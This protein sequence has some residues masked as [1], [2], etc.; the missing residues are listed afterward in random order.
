[1]SFASATRSSKEGPMRF[2]GQSAIVT[3]AAS[4]IGLAIARRLEGEGARVLP[5]DRNAA[6][7]AV[8]ANSGL[9]LDLT[10]DD[11]PMRVAEEASRRFGTVDILVNNAGGGAL[12]TL[13]D[14]DDAL[15]DAILATNL[16]AV[17]RVTREIIPLLARPGGRIVNIASIF[18]EVGFPKAPVYGVTKAG[19]SLLTRQLAA[20]LTPQGIR[21]NAVAPGVIETPGNTHF[22]HTDVPYRRHMND[23]VPMG[24]IG[25]PH[26]IA[27]VVAFLC[28]EDASYVSGQ[29]IVV[30]GGWLTTRYVPG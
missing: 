29:V 27:G 24:R 9:T 23:M 6:G 13:E 10:D 28:S 11:A 3:G 4:G 26:E 19:I 12:K 20:D 5:V 22:I 21:V 8:L 18:G 7:M 15:I 25:Q 16:R 14:S 30:D 17:L 1:M 2:D